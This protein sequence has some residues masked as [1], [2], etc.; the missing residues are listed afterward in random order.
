V[1]TS[2]RALNAIRGVPPTENWRTL[3][4]GIAAKVPDYPEGDTDADAKI[5][6]VYNLLWPAYTGL[7]SAHWSRQTLADVQGVL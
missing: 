1:S 3:L 7:S 5:R 6:K 4:E 2:Q